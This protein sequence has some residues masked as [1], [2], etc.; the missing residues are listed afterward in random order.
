MSRRSEPSTNVGTVLPTR[1]AVVRERSGGE[2]MR[3]VV[4]DGF[5]GVDKLVHTTIPKPLPRDGEVDIAQQVV[6]AAGHPGG[7]SPDGVR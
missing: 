1:P 4:R 3:A 2:S 6:G 5:G 7:P